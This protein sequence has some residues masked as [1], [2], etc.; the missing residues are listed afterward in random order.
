MNLP[1]WAS[2]ALALLLLALILALIAAAVFW[3]RTRLVKPAPPAAPLAVAAL[4]KSMFGAAMATLYPRDNDLRYD[5]PCVLVCGAAASGSGELLRGAGLE[6]VI[7]ATGKDSGWWRSSEGVAFALPAAA[8]EA[9]GDAWTGFLRLL[10]RHRGRRALDAIV[11]QIPFSALDN[12]SAG[13]ERMYRKFVDIQDRLGLRLP[14]YVVVTGCDEVDGFGRWAARLPEAARAQALG[15]SNPNA[16]G[17]PWRSSDGEQGVARLVNRLRL[18]VSAVSTRRDLG[19]D[20]AS[21]FVMPDQLGKVLGRLPPALQEAMR[22]NAVMTPFDLRGVYLSGRIRARQDAAQA[23]PFGPAAPPAQDSAPVF[24]R[25]LFAN[26]VFGEFGLAQVVQRRLDAEKRSQLVVLS[27]ACLLAALWLVCLVPSYFATRDQLLSIEQPLRGIKA[28]LLAPPGAD[29]THDEVEMKELLTEIDRLQDWHTP[30]YALPPS[31]HPYLGGLRAEIDGVLKTYYQRVLF[32]N[33]DRA[34]RARAVALSESKHAA[35]SE[36]GALAPNP[37]GVTQFAALSKFVDAV[38]LFEYQRNNFNDVTAQHHGSWKEIAGLLDYLFEMKLNDASPATVARFDRLLKES[39]YLANKGVDAEDDTQLRRQLDRLHQDFLKGAFEHNRLFALQGELLKGI[40]TLNEEKSGEQLQLARLQKNISELRT[41]LTRTDAAWMVDGQLVNSDAY[42]KLEAGIHKSRILGER[43]GEL[44]ATAMARQQAFRNEVINDDNAP[45]LLDYN[46]GKHLQVNADLGGL[47]QALGKL[48]LQRFAQGA[49]SE[50]T[51][52]GDARAPLAWNTEQLTAAQAVMADLE[53]Y[54]AKV[55]IEAPASFQATLRKLARLQAGAVIERH[56]ALAVSAATCEAGWRCANFEDARKALTPLVAGMR[57]LEIS[58]AAQHWERLMDTQALALLA[59]LKS[60]LDNGNLY[61]PDADTIA[62]WDGTL[63]GAPLGYGVRGGDGELRDYLDAQ[64]Q[65][66]GEMTMASKGPRAWLAQKGV[67][68]ARETQALLGDWNRVDAE[69]AKHAAKVPT[70]SLAR[71]E[72]WFADD[73]AKLEITDCAER[74]PPAANAQA[75]F[76][77]RRMSKVAAMFGRRCFDLE[78]GEARR[79][80][81]LIAAHF[82]QHL[83]DRYPFAAA[84]DAVAAEPQQVRHL[85]QL[86]EANKRTASMLLKRQRDPAAM[87][88]A[89]FIKR[90]AAVQPILTAVLAEDPAGGF[91]A[92]DLWPQF[93][94]NREREKGGDQIFEWLMDINGVPLNTDGSAALPWRM[95]DKIALG[96]RWAKNSSLVPAADLAPPGMGIERATVTWRYDD[97]WALLRLLTEHA[98]PESDLSAS[99][100]RRPVVLRFKVPTRDKQGNAADEAVVYARLEVSVH[101]KPERLRVPPFPTGAAPAL[102]VPGTRITAN[103][104]ENGETR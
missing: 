54:E 73:L 62:A 23:D 64:L 79:S 51:A 1:L 77:Q 19:S 31:W 11:W 7:V 74:L 6:P 87:A 78:G 83:W 99:D 98:A 55:L 8:W 36:T 66:V 50:A 95:A 89:D 104:N 91:A 35:A 90:L 48:L 45:R 47:E 67:L 9:Q 14:V 10:D 29:G 72:K 26:R 39:S 5:K 94:V 52:G 75:D 82:N 15:W 22:E 69:L 16:L 76:F 49:S 85:L 28:A 32:Q 65:A 70:G 101:G 100:A 42:R 61:L 24:C 59:V 58:N 88:A 20:A 56:L 18:L 41:L 81:G 30:S 96:L 27:G 71:L 57:H 102:L 63:G 86:L 2:L 103:A 43:A 68:A 37:E 17:T 97:T 3:R 80:Y 12:G 53:S 21:I 46:E 93:R 60:A 13:G 84:R 40:R 38:R 25:E 34:L 4:Q 33:I 92:L 44:R